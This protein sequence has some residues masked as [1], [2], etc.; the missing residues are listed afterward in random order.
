METEI[1]KKC[2]EEMYKALEEVAQYTIDGQ[3][4]FVNKHDIK[5]W[6]KALENI[7]SHPKR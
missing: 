7:T 2:Q 6:I 3:K 5:V 1:I 4:M